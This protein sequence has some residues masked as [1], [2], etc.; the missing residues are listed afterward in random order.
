MEDTLDRLSRISTYAA[1]RCGGASAH[2]FPGSS[3]HIRRERNA[4]GLDDVVDVVD[5]G[6][7]A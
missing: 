4:D 7:T 5:R 1:E 3:P 6:L 2:R